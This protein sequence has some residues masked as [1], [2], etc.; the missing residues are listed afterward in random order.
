MDLSSS[1]RWESCGRS[2]TQCE[3]SSGLSLKAPCLRLGAAP[4]VMP[5]GNVHNEV[6]M[7]SPSSRGIQ[8]ATKSKISSGS[9][10]GSR[11]APFQNCRITRSKYPDRSPICRKQLSSPARH[12]R[13]AVRALR[14]SR[15]A[16]RA[17]ALAL[18][19]GE[20]ALEL[21]H[22][23]VLV[24]PLPERRRSIGSVGVDRVA[25]E[26]SFSSHPLA[27]FAVDCGFARR[28]GR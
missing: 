5:A 9:F 21:G 15:R 25:G 14:R 13:R 3:R 2:C 16:W 19:L 20:L 17:I 11:V 1:L 8:S 7:M 22:V 10:G 24:R 12:A 28:G 23:R 18:E 4:P 6:A 26:C 27:E